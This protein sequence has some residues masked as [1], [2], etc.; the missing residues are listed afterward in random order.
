[1]RDLVWSIPSWFISSCSLSLHKNFSSGS[2]KVI[3]HANIN[4]GEIQISA[5]CLKQQGW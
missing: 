1:M 5:L 4:E 2:K 3:L